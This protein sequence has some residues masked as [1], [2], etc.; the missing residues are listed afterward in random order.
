M[1]AG[2]QAAL[3]ALLLGGCALAL[4]QVAPPAAPAAPPGAFP[5]LI[6][7][8][9]GGTSFSVPIQTLLFFTALS[10]LPAVLL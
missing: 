10:F 3:A 8:G 7:Q 1:R 6:G 4:A 2:A 5:I 9:A